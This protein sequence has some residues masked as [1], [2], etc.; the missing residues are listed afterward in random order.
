MLTSGYLL[1]KKEGRLGSPEKPLSDLGF[2][3][4]RSYWA[5]A[6]FRALL[7]IEGDAS[8][9]CESRTTMSEATSPTAETRVGGR[10]QEDEDDADADADAEDDAEDER[11]C[12]LSLRTGDEDV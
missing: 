4:Y 3:T 7:T 1:S 6:V 11:T 2:L 12:E 10:E 8:V 9:E 5:L